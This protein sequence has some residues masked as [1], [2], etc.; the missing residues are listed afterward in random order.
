MSTAAQFKTPVRFRSE[1]I[2]IASVTAVVT[3][4][5]LEIPNAD[6]DRA[7]V[8]INAKKQPKTAYTVDSST[9]ITFS[10]NLE[11]GDFVEVTIPG[12]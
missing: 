6:E 8:H 12:Y 3:L 1:E 10:E 4:S 7:I 11:I 9:Q 2:T 5:V